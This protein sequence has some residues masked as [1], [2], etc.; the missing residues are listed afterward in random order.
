MLAADMDDTLVRIDSLQE[1]VLGAA[2]RNPVT[3]RGVVTCP[4][5][6]VNYRP[7][8]DPQSVLLPRATLPTIVLLCEFTHLFHAWFSALEGLV[9]S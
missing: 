1:D 9:A 2:L 5:Q 6:I 8:N 7:T 3:S 4:W